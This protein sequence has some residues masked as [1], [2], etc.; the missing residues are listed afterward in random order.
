M[1]GAVIKSERFTGILAIRLESS[2]AVRGGSRN[3]FEVYV[4]R[5]TWGRDPAYTRQ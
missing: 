1:A 3:A 2:D 4:D 5:F